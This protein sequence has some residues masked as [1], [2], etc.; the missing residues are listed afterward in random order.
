MVDVRRADAVYIRFVE[1]RRKVIFMNEKFE[2]FVRA[3]KRFEDQDR[4]SW[5]VSSRLTGEVSDNSVVAD[6]IAK[7]LQ[8][9]DEKLMRM[10]AQAILTGSAIPYTHRKTELVSYTSDSK[11]GDFY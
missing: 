11:K 3:E 8:K 5:D 4:E 9:L 10:I 6:I 7:V 2:F 1:L